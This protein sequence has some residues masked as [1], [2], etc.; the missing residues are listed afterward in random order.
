M[1]A[2]LPKIIDYSESFPDA[3][4]AEG[5]GQDVLILYQLDTPRRNISG[6]ICRYE[7]THRWLS[8]VCA[9]DEDQAWACVKGSDYTLW[10]K[11]QIDPETSLFDQFNFW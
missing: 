6:H 9:D 1:T 4:K 11:R 10:T 2:D 8:V 5:R 7:L 3:L